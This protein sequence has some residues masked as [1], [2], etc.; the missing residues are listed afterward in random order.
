L[1]FL[2]LFAAGRSQNR[3][4]PPKMLRILSAARP[5]HRKGMHSKEL[6]V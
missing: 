1:G 5:P 4:T 3:L 6:E 2:V